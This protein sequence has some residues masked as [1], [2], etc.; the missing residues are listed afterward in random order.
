MAQDPRLHRIDS[1]G[2]PSGGLAVRIADLERRMRVAEMIPASPWVPLT[3]GAGITD[4]HSGVRVSGIDVRLRGALQNTSGG[5]IGFV[6]IATLPKQAWPTYN[7]Y[8]V[9]VAYDPGSGAT[10]P[11]PVWVQPG[12]NVRLMPTVGNGVYVCLDGF[13]FTTN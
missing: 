3:M 2:D 10:T 11:V 8:E 9:V 4:A 13:T 5:P 6:V 1:S 7:I 12:G